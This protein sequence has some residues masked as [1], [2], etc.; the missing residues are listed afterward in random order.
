AGEQLRAGE[1]GAGR[2]AAAR[3]QLEARPLAAVGREV[4]RTAVEAQLGGGAV[5]RGRHL[6]AARLA[7]DGERAARRNERIPRQPTAGGE[8]EARHRRVRLRRG[9]AADL[10][11]LHRGRRL[12]TGE[13][14]A[15]GEGQREQVLAGGERAVRQLD[16]DQLPARVQVDRGRGLAGDRDL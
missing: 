15:L 16:R 3:G 11:E 12:L 6:A 1:R 2:A 14:A 4:E 8:G 5:D 13:G 9:A 7:R 10:D